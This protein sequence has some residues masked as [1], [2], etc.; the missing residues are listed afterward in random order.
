MQALGGEQIT[1]YSNSSFKVDQCLPQPKWCVSYF[2]IFTHKHKILDIAQWG[3]V[4][5]CHMSQSL[6]LTTWANHCDQP[7]RANHIPVLTLLES[8]SPVH[9]YK[10][11]LSF[12]VFKAWTS[13][14]LQFT[15][16]SLLLMKL[17]LTP[18]AIARITIKASIWHGEQ[19]PLNGKGYKITQRSY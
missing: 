1:N 9:I 7:I 2:P 16:L 12:A 6:W 10:V 11:K 14:K 17:L 5:C 13:S 15:D 4:K 8:L 18:K 3:S 19:G